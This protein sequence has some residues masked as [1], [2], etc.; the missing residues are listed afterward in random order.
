MPLIMRTKRSKKYIED[1][2]DEL[3]VK[4]SQV[5]A[6]ADSMFDFVADTISEADRKRMN[7][8]DIRLMNWGIFTVRESKRKQFEKVNNERS[9]RTDD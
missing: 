2:A 5:K 1:T 3:G 4:P 9:T 6:V 7:F 8:P